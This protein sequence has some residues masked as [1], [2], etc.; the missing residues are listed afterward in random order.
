MAIEPVLPGKQGLLS[1]PRRVAGTHIEI[2]RPFDGR[3]LRAVLLDFDG[4]LSLE[5]DGWPNLMVATNSAALAQ[6]VP[7]VSPAE[8]IDWVIRDIEFNI[9]APTFVQM[10]RLAA[11]IVR[12]G[13]VATDAGRYKAV[14]NHAL[15]AMV[16]AVHSRL[17]SGQIHIADLTVS[18]AFDLL[19]ALRDQFGH[20]ALHLASGTDIAPVR[21]SVRLLGFDVFFCDGH[22]EPAGPDD[23]AGRNDR[24]ACFSNR[25][26]AAGSTGDPE[27]CAKELVIAKLVAEE[28]LQ[29]GQLLCFGDGFP[30][31]LHAYRAGG[32]CVGVVTPDHS[33]YESQGHFSVAQ[34]RERLVHA[35][36]H[37]LVPD[38]R[39]AETLVQVLR[40]GQSGLKP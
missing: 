38:F 5:R 25:I 13:G 6:A 4:T 17:A 11:E 36:A 2:V 14:Y 30:E 40:S 9:G 23:P 26:I 29:P 7:G 21:E 15:V 8:A 28:N 31:I 34:K 35:G 19:E 10:K 12:R 18:G 24:D 20:R 22:G 3:A 1:E 33:Y 32:V 37:V 27:Q 16:A 39:D